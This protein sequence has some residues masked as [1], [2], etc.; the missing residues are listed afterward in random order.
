MDDAFYN[1]IKTAFRTKLQK[2]TTP[3]EVIKFYGALVK[4][5]TCRNLIQVKKNVIKIN[6]EL[7]MYHLELNSFKNTRRLGFS[8]EAKQY[9]GFESNDVPYMDGADLGFDD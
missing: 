9:F 6:D 4:S 5:A 8:P 2:P 1:L 7:A 3:E